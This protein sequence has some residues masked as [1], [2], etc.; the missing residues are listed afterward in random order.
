MA[1]V[2]GPAG[3]GK[4]TL[5]AEW[6][7]ADPRIFT[8][9]ML[10]ARHNDPGFLFSSI[11]RALDRTEPLD[12]SVFAALSAPRPSIEKVVAPRLADSLAWRQE[13]FVLVLDDAHE[14]HDPALFGPLAAVAERLPS[15]C[16]LAIAS[17][18]EPP[19]PFGRLRAH[20]KLVELHA[21][22]LLMGRGEAQQLLQASGIEVSSEAVDRLMD[23][24]EGWPAALYLAALAIR[25]QEDPEQAVAT[26]A[27]DDRLVADYLWDELLSGLTEDELDFLTRTSIL[28]RLSGPL[29]D[30]V[31]ER[32]G[33]AKTLRALSRSNLLLTPLDH[34]DE[35]FRYHALFG[36]M[37]QA[38]LARLGERP[39]RELH[40]R[41][42]RWYE[43]QGDVD[44]TVSHAIASGDVHR[45]GWLVWAAAA[46][47][48]SR[49]RVATVRRWLDEF[50]PEQ[51][52][53][54]PTLAL[55]RA[56]TFLNVGAGPE[57]DHWAAVASKAADSA[58]KLQRPA[59]RASAALLRAT[60]APRKGLARMGSDVAGAHNLIP[61][62]NPWRSLCCF[63]EG[64]AQHLLGDR[65]LARPLLQ[66]GASFG[67][68]VAPSIHVSCLAQLA[69]LSLDEDDAD[70]AATL[71]AKASA[72]SERVGLEEEASAAN[73][74]ATSAVT[75]ARRGRV[76]DATR[77]VK[78]STRNLAGFS[79]FAAWYEAQVRIT[80][81][82][83]LLLLD[84][85]AGARAHLRDAGSY[86]RSVADAVVLRE[87]HREAQ[88]EAD[89]A[90]AGGRWP[91]TPAEIRLLH[92]MPT[93]LSF[94]EIAER[95]FVTNNT[96]KTQ[97]GAIYRKLDVSSRAEAVQTARAG[98]LLDEGGIPG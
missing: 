92:Y 59:L 85:V 63:L 1:L 78:L 66:E 60:A 12:E 19:L 43:R 46:D 74:F 67:A 90:S 3:Y 79:D 44:R 26:F 82:R 58:A 42:S 52:A 41:A 55:T 47:Y 38:E 22:D 7:G 35:Q 25:S 94:P 93:H 36:G 87:W 54:S 23:R 24:T 91:L 32:E 76:A 5:L 75:L 96:V 37:L 20:R 33:S 62:D 29:C 2:V 10:D 49:G 89:R 11:A 31:L 39:Q 65:E 83:A 34:R 73:V 18:A 21:E 17:R 95:L 72:E 16:Q 15:R 61:E 48:L 53:D 70:G 64:A 28:D 8:W 14:L 51:V 80:L 40:E 97:A 86:L 88:A 4:T 57:A 50:T 68:A 45:A 84:D 27:G 71:A 98:G 6:E 9:V 69:L 30:A 81:A 56:A 77:H 13:P